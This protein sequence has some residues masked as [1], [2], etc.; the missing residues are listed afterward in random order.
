MIVDVGHGCDAE[1]NG[2]RRPPGDSGQALMDS[3]VEGGV[4][5]VEG[6]TDP[7]GGG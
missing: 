2:W 4:G 3:G 5:L 1:G 6:V 7:H